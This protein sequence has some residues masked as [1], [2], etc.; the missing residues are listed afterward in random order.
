ME[1]R[2]V[3]WVR[4]YGRVELCLRER[5]EERGLTRNH[6]ARQVNT[7]YEVIDKWYKNEVEKIDADI[8]A[9]MCFVLDCGVEELLVY[10]QN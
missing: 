8:L 5:M 7:R 10:R 3:T 2:S 9:R 1:E 4:A 6:L